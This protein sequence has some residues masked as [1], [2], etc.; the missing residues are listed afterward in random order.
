MLV[1][2]RSARAPNRCVVTSDRVL[3]GEV[4]FRHRP[5]FTV[6]PSAILGNGGLLILA[7]PVVGLLWRRAEMGGR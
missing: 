7:E 6:N 1:S 3:F 2:L 4:D 5:Y